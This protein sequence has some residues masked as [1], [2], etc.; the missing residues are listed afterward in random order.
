MKLREGGNP[1]YYNNGSDYLVAQVTKLFIYISKADFECF[2][3]EFEEGACY[4]INN[5]KFTEKRGIM[6]D[7]P[8]NR[9]K[10]ESCRR[11]ETISIA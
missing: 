10:V 1:A 3:D 8:D 4:V 5:F 9:R 11:W 6:D 2:T 7:G